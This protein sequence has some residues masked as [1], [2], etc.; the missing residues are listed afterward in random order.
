MVSHM[1][2]MKRER[3]E[4]TSRPPNTLPTMVP[5]NFPPVKVDDPF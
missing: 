5:A 1:Y 3:R 2:D 4:R